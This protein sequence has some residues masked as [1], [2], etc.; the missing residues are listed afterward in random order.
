MWGSLRGVVAVA[1]VEKDG[2]VAMRRCRGS[3]VC[4]SVAHHLIMLFLIQ[5]KSTK[6]RD[7][8]LLYTNNKEILLN[9]LITLKI[10]ILVM[11]LDQK[12]SHVAKFFMFSQ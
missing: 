1:Y 10:M 5:S 8:K 3:E 12:Q 7:K 9:G 11:L 6:P 2:E 4:T